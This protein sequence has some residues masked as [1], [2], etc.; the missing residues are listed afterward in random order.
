[1]PKQTQSPLPAVPNTFASSPT[2]SPIRYPRPASSTAAPSSFGSFSDGLRSSPLAMPPPPPASLASTSGSRRRNDIVE[3]WQPPSFTSQPS[4]SSSIDYPT[5]SPQQNLLPQP[6]PAASPALD[7]QDRRPIA[8]LQ[9]TQS[10]SISPPKPS[11]GLLI[12][13]NWPVTTWGDVE[14]GVSGLK[15]LGNTCYMNSTL[16]CLSAT[17]P[18]VRFFAG[19]TCLSCANRPRAHYIDADGRWKTAV[20]MMN[21]LGSKGHLAQIFA[22]MISEMWRHEYTYLSPL[23]FRVQYLPSSSNEAKPLMS[24][25]RKGSVHASHSSEVPTSMTLKSSLVRCWMDYTRI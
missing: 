3:R 15:N 8:A 5:L 1:M 14:I 24:T 4:R 23:T 6:P 25:F 21:P 7:R 12:A 22:T 13:S 9:Q 17:V 18:F 11:A 16:Q 10:Y 20:N 2:P 19:M